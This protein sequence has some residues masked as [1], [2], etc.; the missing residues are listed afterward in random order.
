MAGIQDNI[1]IDV[2]KYTKEYLKFALKDLTEMSVTSLQ[3]SFDL[4]N[5]DNEDFESYNDIIKDGINENTAKI[6]ES[7]NTIK[8]NLKEEVRSII[9]ENSELSASELQAV[10]KERLQDTFTKFENRAS[11]IAETSTNAGQNVVKSKS[12][13]RNAFV[14]VWLS[15]RDGRVRFSHKA[16]DGKQA[17]DNGYFKV[18]TDKMQYPCG[19]SKAK[20]NVRCRC[21][22]IARKRN[23]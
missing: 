18:G 22:V 9:A 19:G 23:D 3:E 15:Q 10:L 7:I 14:K 20:E 5:L 21:K 16:I 13:E 1:D 17:D 6:K 8:S 11:M 2:D 12:I 4:M